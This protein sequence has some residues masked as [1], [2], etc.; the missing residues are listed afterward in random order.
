MMAVKRRFSLFLL[1]G[2]VVSSASGQSV[3]KSTD[4]LTLNFRPQS[5]MPLYGEPGS[6]HRLELT[7]KNSGLAGDFSV[8]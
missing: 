2:V 7:L 5:S 8:E 3:I 6:L 4:E 1:A